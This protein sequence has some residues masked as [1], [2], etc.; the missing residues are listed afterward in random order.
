MVAA[1]S[2][3]LKQPQPP[4]QDDDDEPELILDNP[5]KTLKHLFLQSL[6]SRRVIP[7]DL[8]KKIYEKAGALC[9]G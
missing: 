6:M 4:A 8:A 9:G 5:E 1:T 3:K 2:K 7:A